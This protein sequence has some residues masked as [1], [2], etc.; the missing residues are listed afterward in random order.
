MLSFV[1]I[2]LHLRPLQ[3]HISVSGALF[4]ATSKSLPELGLCLTWTTSHKAIR[5]PTAQVWKRGL[6]SS[7][8][9]WMKRS[10]EVSYTALCAVRLKAENL[11][12]NGKH[13]LGKG[14]C[15]QYTRT[16]SHTSYQPLIYNH[17]QWVGGNNSSY[18]QKT[19]KMAT[20]LTCGNKSCSSSESK[21]YTQSQVSCFHKFCHTR[22]ISWGLQL[23][24]ITVFGS[25]MRLWC[26][27]AKETKFQI[28]T[29]P[30]FPLFPCSLFLI[31][32]DLYLALS[33]T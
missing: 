21:Q 24:R 2:H 22:C 32:S 1:T 31:Q 17:V 6:S 7:R 14:I 26:S 10:L 25:E 20:R 33:C 28:K 19:T 11:G 4:S 8:C 29:I 27:R 3:K 9:S 30:V 5:K 12:L 15:E 23:H 16:K 13:T 18:K